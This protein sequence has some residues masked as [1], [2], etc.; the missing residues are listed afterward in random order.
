MRFR[1]VEGRQ[2]QRGPATYTPFE[3]FE[4]EGD[5]AEALL[6]SDL[7]VRVD[8]PSPLPVKK[9]ERRS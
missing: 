8:R 2:L 4:A 7:V 5:E 9:R 6:A 1:V 3:E